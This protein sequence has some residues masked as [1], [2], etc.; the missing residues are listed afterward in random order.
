MLVRLLQIRGLGTPYTRTFPI[1]L[2]QARDNWRT[3]VYHMGIITDFY[4]NITGPEIENCNLSK[5]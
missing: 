1:I 2:R 5:K 3:S 4:K